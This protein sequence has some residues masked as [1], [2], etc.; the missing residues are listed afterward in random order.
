[1]V[2]HVSVSHAYLENHIYIFIKR[3]KG[4]KLKTQTLIPKFVQGLDPEE[5]IEKCE[6]EW[7]KL[8]IEMKECGLIHFQA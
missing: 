7:K 5:H 8:D 1:M 3:I 6:K 4:K 2:G